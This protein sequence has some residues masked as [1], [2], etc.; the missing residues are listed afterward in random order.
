[1]FDK[2][3]LQLKKNLKK[4]FSNFRK[5]KIGILG[6]NSTQFLNIALKGLGYDYHLNLDIFEA[7][8]DQIPLQVFDTFSDLYKYLQ[9]LYAQISSLSHPIQL[10]FGGCI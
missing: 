5:I 2:S 4:D 9:H 1:M 10:A 8:Y 3:F 7:D 6:D